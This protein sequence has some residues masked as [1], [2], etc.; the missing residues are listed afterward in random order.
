MSGSGQET[1]P[2]VRERSG[3]PPGC[4]VVVGRLSQ[5]SESGREA[6]LKVHEVSGGPPG[7]PG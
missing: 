2:K 3:A 1:L 7:C 6:L 5:M 4:P